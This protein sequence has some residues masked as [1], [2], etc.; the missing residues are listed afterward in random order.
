VKAIG[1]P[2]V[3]ELTLYPPQPDAGDHA[4]TAEH[5]ESGQLLGEQ[6]LRRRLSD[7]VFRRLQ[8]DEAARADLEGLGRVAA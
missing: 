4:A 6:A 7:E 3:G 1:G 2:Q 8:A 5:V